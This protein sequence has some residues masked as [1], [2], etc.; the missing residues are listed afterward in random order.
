MAMANPSGW[1]QDDDDSDDAVEKTINNP[2]VVASSA[3]EEST[4]DLT[5]FGAVLDLSFRILPS[6]DS[7]KKSST[8]W[9]EKRGCI[10]DI[11]VLLKKGEGAEFWRKVAT[12]VRH[13]EGWWCPVKIVNADS[14]EI[15]TIRLGH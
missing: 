7:L 6:K 14:V 12:K 1:R 9:S 8:E 15:H 5:E 10:P 11:N 3:Q 4:H 2:A 13:K